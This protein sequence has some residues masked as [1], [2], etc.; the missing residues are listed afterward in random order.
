MTPPIVP[1]VPDEPA[2]SLAEV[3]SEDVALRRRRNRRLVWL[4]AAMLLGGGIV[5]GLLLIPLPY[6]VMQPGSVRPSERSI[7]VT[8]AD[9][10]VDDGEILF[11]TVMMRRATP[12]LLLQSLVDEAIEVRSREEVYPD[13]DVDRSRELNVARMDLSKLIATRVALDHL[14]IDASFDASGARV[15][16]LSEDSP[17]EGL[18]RPGDVIVMVDGGE[19]AMPSDI[20]EELDDREPGEI[21]DVELLRP[22]RGAGD[23][24][25]RTELSVEL[26]AA[27]DGAG[28]VRPVLGIEVEPADLSVRSD[29]DVVLDSGSVSGPSAGLA[30]T[31]GILDRLT[32]GSMTAGRRVAVT[33]EI[34]DDGSV[35]AVGGLVQKVAAVDR[36]GIDVFIFPASTPEAEQAEMRRIASDDL[37][38]APVATLEEAVAALVPEGLDGPH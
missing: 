32:P 35:G 2:P 37:Q 10:F 22:G 9:S 8:G 20:G 17:S 28:G 26:G 14:G 12:A 23:E 3:Q 31:L 36:A 4:V 38:L 15:L 21:V 29:V 7:E 34:H 1:T 5:A 24:V 33:G 25:E 19:V 16:G 6:Y 18:I 30:W 27:D 13:G 11:P